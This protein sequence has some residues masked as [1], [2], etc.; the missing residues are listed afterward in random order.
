[1]Y[2]DVGPNQRRF[3]VYKGWISSKSTF[4]KAAFNG[5]FKEASN[6]V[7]LLPDDDPELFDIVHIW[8]N[9]DLLTQSVNGRDVDCTS[10]QLIDVFIF[11]DKYGMPELQNMAI[12][13]LI[14][15]AVKKEGLIP[16]FTHV[17]GNTTKNSPLR[18]LL[19]DL[20]AFLPQSWAEIARG[21]PDLLYECPEFVLDV[22]I[23]LADGVFHRVSPPSKMAKAPF[24]NR[25]GC[26][27]HTHGEGV[28]VCSML[29]I[30]EKHSF[31]SLKLVPD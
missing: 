10:R 30:P 28:E 21:Y 15:W 27:Y 17:Y 31:S 2:V 16:H 5:S 23:A 18:R 8:L 6:D 7:V 22:S 11:G 14:E 19:V 26:D 12:N 13:Y 4:F 1:M 20:F 24:V 3:G 9:V 29:E 25:N